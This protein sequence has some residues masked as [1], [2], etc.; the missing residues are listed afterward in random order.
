MEFS[1]D[2]GVLQAPVVEIKENKPIETGVTVRQGD[3]IRIVS[4]EY[5]TLGKSQYVLVKTTNGKIIQGYIHVGYIKKPLS[6]E[7]MDTKGINFRNLDAT[8]RKAKSPIN[9]IVNQTEKN[10]QLRA[11]DIINI[12]DIGGTFSAN[13][14]FIDKKGNPVFW[15]VYYGEGDILALHRYSKILGISGLVKH[16]HEEIQDFLHDIV[17]YLEGEYENEDEI[18]KSQKLVRVLLGADAEEE[19]RDKKE[20]VRR[21]Q[22]DIDRMESQ[23]GELES[24]GENT[25]DIK[26]EIKKTEEE[27]NTLKKEIEELINKKSLVKELNNE[28]FNRT[29]NFISSM[30]IDEYNK[31]LTDIRKTGRN[32]QEAL[33]KEGFQFTSSQI[34]NMN[35]TEYKDFLQ[36]LGFDYG[37]I[38]KQSSKLS[39]PV[40]RSIEDAKLKRM[41]VY[42]MDISF[43]PN[44]FGPNNVQLVAMG[45]MK[46]TPLDHTEATYE[47]SFSSHMTTNE[48]V[49]HIHEDYQP[50]L[51][52][53][54]RM[55]GEFEVDGEKYHGAKISI[56]SKL[57][58]TNMSGSTEI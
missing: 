31:Y 43:R 46:I 17:G 50:V 25:K 7:I 5:R 20:E 2:R 21:L 48:D 19:D 13:Y 11:E 52:A 30:G 49:R 38:S 55:G 10:G 47:L 28:G 4:S 51:F 54:P 34:R 22:L 1:I 27:M 14:A 16:R 56:E 36:T 35:N 53:E 32:I 39:H 23:M 29:S 33:N 26:K 24:R 18:K 44:T 3:S 9:I 12:R 57:L 6:S 42:G 37:S 40:W 8:I 45:N 58:A 15:V 41:F